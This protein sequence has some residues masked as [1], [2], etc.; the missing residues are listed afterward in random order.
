MALRRP[1]YLLPAATLALALAVFVADAL[2][3]AD[4][5]FSGAY[6]VVVLMAGRFCR[7]RRLV[8]V[9]A[10]CAGLTILAQ[11]WADHFTVGAAQIASI[12]A[13]NTLDSVLVIG[14]AT[15]FILRGQAAEVALQRAQSD[16]AR[17]SRVTVMGELTAS[18]AHEVNQPIAAAVTNAR[19]CLRWLAADTPNLEEARAAA[20]R[21]VDDGTR[22]AEIIARIRRFF[23]KG[24]AEQRPV[25]LNQLTRETVE[26]IAPEAARHAVSV[27]TDLER[28]LPPVLGDGVQLQQV[29]VNLMLNAIEAMHATAGP[30]ELALKTG[31][32]A[33]DTV[34]LSVSDVG[35]GLPPQQEIFDAFVTTKAEGTGMGLSISRSII[36]THQGRIWAAAN[37]P[38]VATFSF[39]L[40]AHTPD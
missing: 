25:D 37:R 32:S 12:G 40:P 17:V 26:L 36:E 4:C 1:A 18:I 31:R 8:L 2:T 35:Q 27:R 20:G 6:A 10:G 22:A 7:G 33:R 9:A 29:L 11:I 39:S 24:A 5:V 28:D 13:F 38:S 16:L 15:Y 19:A 34:T 14:L 23:V 3:P 21:I 30:R